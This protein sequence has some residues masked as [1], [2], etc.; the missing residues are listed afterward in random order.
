MKAICYVTSNKKKVLEYYH[1]AG[2]DKAM[3]K[4]STMK[5]TTRLDSHAHQ[6]RTCLR[7]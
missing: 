6:V 5:F 1:Y 3:R 4:L 7:V 2:T